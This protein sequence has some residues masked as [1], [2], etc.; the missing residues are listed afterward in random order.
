MR[1][2]KAGAGDLG[3]IA[4]VKN[5]FCGAAQTT[6]E[7][8]ARYSVSGVR[9][10]INQLVVF[11]LKYEV[12]TAS[13]LAPSYHCTLRVPTP[14]SCGPVGVAVPTIHFCSGSE[15]GFC[16]RFSSLMEAPTR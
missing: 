11:V 14:V 12:F 3:I 8:P 10:K 4:S 1:T 9:G 6:L 15:I 16:D 13:T 5:W 7:L 2:V